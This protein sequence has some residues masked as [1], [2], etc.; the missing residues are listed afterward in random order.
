MLFVKIFVITGSS[1]LWAQ[2]ADTLNVHFL[3]GSK[4]KRK[5]R[6][7]EQ[8]WF[9]GKLGGHVGVQLNHDEILHFVPSGKFHY[10]TKKNVRNSRFASDSPEQFYRIFGTPK[11]SV[12][13]LIVSIPVTVAQRVH[14]ENISAAYQIQTPYD[15]AFLGMRCAAASR[16]V[17]GK[18]GVM[19]DWPNGKTWRRTFY[20][21]KLRNRLIRNARKNDWNIEF[22]QGSKRRKWER[23]VESPNV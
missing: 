12:K 7:T 10:I 14:F 1:A 18:S 20:P 8:N 23:D 22:Q 21:R 13:Y 5:F 15:Y 9:G 4:P 16:D 11:D 3:Y 2:S 17:L 6:A 19:K